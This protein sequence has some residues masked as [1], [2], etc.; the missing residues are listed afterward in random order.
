MAAAA[1]P[2]SVDPSER[3][4]FIKKHSGGVNVLYDYARSDIETFRQKLQ[5][6]SS[7]DERFQ[8]LQMQDIGGFT[9]LHY[10]AAWSATETAQ[11][12]LES[13]SEEMRY[14]LHSMENNDKWTPIHMACVLW[15]Y[16]VLEMM[17]RLM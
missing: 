16:E 6:I 14:T 11:V 13:V 7:D 1:V 10:A 9:V 17:L 15:N 5:S 4:T 8:L 12:I 2:Q 3:L